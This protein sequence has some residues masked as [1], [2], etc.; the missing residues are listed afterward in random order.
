[1][2][3]YESQTEKPT[4]NPKSM[5]HKV[6]RMMHKQKSMS[7][8]RKTMMHKQNFINESGGFIIHKKR[9]PSKPSF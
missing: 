5:I 6:E 4:A 3:K 8:K 1:M 9:W 7:H 2:K